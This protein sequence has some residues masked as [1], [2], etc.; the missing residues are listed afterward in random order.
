MFR[1]LKFLSAALR[2]SSSTFKLD[3][4][5]R[6]CFLLMKPSFRCLD[7]V[8]LQK[9]PSNRNYLGRWSTFLILYFNIATHHDLVQ[10]ESLQEK[11]TS[12]DSVNMDCTKQHLVELALACLQASYSFLLEFQIK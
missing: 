8:L 7:D 2:A 3:T 11:I 4:I 10:W 12:Q 1:S 6:Q 5:T 9:E